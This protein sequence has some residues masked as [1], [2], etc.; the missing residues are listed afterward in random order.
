[1]LLASLLFAATVSCPPMK[2]VCEA[3]VAANTVVDSVGVNIHLHSG[4]TIYGNY[5][6]D[7]KS[8]V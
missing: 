4:D 5:P 1:M 8:V 6:L 3:P 7:R 2:G